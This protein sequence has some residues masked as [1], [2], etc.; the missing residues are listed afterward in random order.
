MD[1]AERTCSGRVVMLLEGGYSL[2]AVPQTVATIISTLAELEDAEV[3]KFSEY[4]HQRLKRQIIEIK[5]ILSDYWN[6]FKR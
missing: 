1:V 2:E 4:K 5:R 6:I 3:M